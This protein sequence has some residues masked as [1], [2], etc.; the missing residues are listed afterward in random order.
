MLIASLVFSAVAYRVP[1]NKRIFHILTVLLTVTSALS[2]LALVSGYGVTKRC[3]GGFGH[4]DDGRIPEIPEIHCYLQSNLRMIEWS[5]TAVLLVANLSLLA[6]LSGAQTFVAAAA[7]LITL[8]AGA[9]VTSG[10]D[11]RWAWLLIVVLSY[12]TV[13][14]QVGVNGTRKAHARGNPV[15]LT[16]LPLVIYTFIL[17]TVQLA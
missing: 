7:N 4:H 11:Q 16:F 10:A 14:W 1:L 15:R 5:V 6:G 8:F 17:W 12:V 2:S 9:A 13:V 3:H